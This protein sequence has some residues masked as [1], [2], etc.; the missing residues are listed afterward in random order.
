MDLKVLNKDG[1]PVAAN[2]EGELY[3]GI[4]CKVFGY[5]QNELETNKKFKQ[6]DGKMYYRTGDIV[7]FDINGDIHWLDRADN[8]LKIRG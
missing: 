5:F 6:I 1:F 4:H 7:R 8:Q 3:I 2:T